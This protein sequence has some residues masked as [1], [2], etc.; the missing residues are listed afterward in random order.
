MY[1]LEEEVR[2]YLDSLRGTKPQTKEDIRCI[3]LT[4]KLENLERIRRDLL[5][6][7]RRCIALVSKVDYSN[8]RPRLVHVAPQDR[9]IWNWYRHILS[10]APWTG[11]PGRANFLFAIDD[12]SGGVL[13][14]VDIGSD[15]QSLGPRDRY[16]T[17]TRERRFRGGLNHLANIG[18]CVC[19]A[20][21]GF[22]TGGK[23]QAVACMSD[24]IRDLWL[25]RYGDD[26]AAVVIT[27]LYGKSAM[28]NRL[29][30]L[31]YLG[32]TP[33]NGV[34]NLDKDGVVLL[35][36]F[37]RRNGL[38]ERI[39]GTAGQFQNKS[40]L[41]ERVCS[42]IGY[43]RDAISSHQPRGVYFGS[44]GGGALDFLRGDAKEFEYTPRTQRGVRDWWLE[45]WYSMRWPKLKDRIGDFDWNN[46]RVDTQIAT[47]RTQLRGR[48][49]IDSAPQTNVETGGA[50]PT[51]PL[52][53]ETGLGLE[54]RLMSAS[55]VVTDD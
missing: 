46:Y 36:A 23:F 19:A 54:P 4:R 48:G 25:K 33:G 9:K 10:S 17:W 30:E 32:I 29:R 11:R 21:F 27:S 13:G 24:S 20:P 22:L 5:V 40:D 12:N 2:G 28:Y 6:H 41:V 35:K 42:T 52:L 51:R 53:S 39:G 14:I 34:A 49:G 50:S 45:R 8:I 37:V 3:L 31:K 1:E 18:T 47:I 15:L 38:A 26:L 55:Q 44:M 7:E 16:I 43:D